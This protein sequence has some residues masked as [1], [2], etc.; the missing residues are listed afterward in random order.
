MAYNDRKEVRKLKNRESAE[1][2]RKEKV[3][4]YKHTDSVIRTN[5]NIY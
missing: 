2:T 3:K 5:V 1:K 4:W